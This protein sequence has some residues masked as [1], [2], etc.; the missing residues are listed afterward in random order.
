LLGRE[1]KKKKTFYIVIIEKLEQKFVSERKEGKERK[2]KKF[3]IVKKI[4]PR[5]EH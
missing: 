2:W 3:K 4:E 5:L 1:K